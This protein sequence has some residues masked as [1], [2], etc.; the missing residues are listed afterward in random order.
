VRR[1]RA[2]TSPTTPK[3]DALPKNVM[4]S[5]KRTAQGV[6]WSWKTARW[7]DRP[8]S[9]TPV[10]RSH[11]QGRTTEQPTRRCNYQQACQE[12]GAQPLARVTHSELKVPLSIHARF[13]GIVWVNSRQNGYT[14]EKAEKRG[15]LAGA[16]RGSTR[17]H[18]TS[19]QPWIV[20]LI[21]GLGKDR[22]HFV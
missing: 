21:S 3:I 14:N 4:A 19:P 16:A 10:H 6:P 2:V 11:R 7:Q 13:R 9:A 1:A 12:H 22:G 18:L 5:N 20:F 17:K 8:A 15:T